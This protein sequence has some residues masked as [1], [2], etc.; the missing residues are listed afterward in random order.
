MT[1]SETLA[2]A[3]YITAKAAYVAA[4]AGGKNTPAAIAAAQILMDLAEELA[5][6]PSPA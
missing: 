6:A 2:D 5:S 3:G 1:V 4:C